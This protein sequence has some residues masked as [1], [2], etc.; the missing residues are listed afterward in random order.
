MNES[1]SNER[2]AAAEASTALRHL[3][4]ADPRLGEIIRR[5]GSYKIQITP[6]PFV[7]LFGSIIHQQLSMK[8]AS[9]IRGRVKA[10]CPRGRVTPA[11]IARLEDQALRGAG[12]SR[13]KV[14]YMSDLCEHFLDKRL[15]TRGLRSMSD[16]Q[17]IEAT[18]QVYGIGRWTAE[19]LLIF[20]L[21][22]PDVWPMD[23][24]GVQ[25]AAQK[26]LGKRKP[27]AMDKLRALADPWRPYR[28]YASWYL[29][30]SL[31]GAIEP[32]LRD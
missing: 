12:L 21:Q 14:S 6:D 24:L 19:M 16:D 27:L 10:L 32:G 28:T 17:V 7:T 5:I 23:D 25:K 2:T 11:N 29:W 9:T 1:K 20:C 26:M 3:R 31:D 18:T 30:R 13:Q 15:T 22:R 4:R 8:A